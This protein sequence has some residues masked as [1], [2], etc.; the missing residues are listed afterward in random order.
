MSF[1]PD[2]WL[3]YATISLVLAWAIWE[4]GPRDLVCWPSVGVGT[5]GLLALAIWGKE[6]GIW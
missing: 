6:I 5:L 3:C 2:F 1:P 4:P